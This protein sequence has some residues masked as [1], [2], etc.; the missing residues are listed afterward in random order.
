MNFNMKTMRHLLCFAVF[1]LAAFC[2]FA[3]ANPYPEE[4]DEYAYAET[5]KYQGQKPIINDFINAYFGEESEDEL[6]GYLS[7]LWHRYLKNEPLDKTEKV[8]LDSKNG[9][10][11]FEKVYPPDEYDTEGS[12]TL[13]EMCYWNSSDGN[14][15]IFAESVQLFHGDRA[16]ETEFSGL[17]FGIYNNATHKITYV[18]QYV[19]GIEV[20]TGMENLGVIVDKGEYFLTNYETNE[21]MP[22]TEEQYN[23]WWNEYPVVTYSL[24]RVGK[25]ITAVINNRPEGK[26][27]IV[28]KWNG[29]RFDVQQ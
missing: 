22:I 11:S 17:V 21:R 12:R 26:K 25:D 1:T 9:F 10:A 19:M 29:L 7:D 23:N 28:V 8:T 20:K 5:V 2:A 27:E 4:N 18:T 13:V 14:H 6:N 15:K 16:I 3:Q 24:P